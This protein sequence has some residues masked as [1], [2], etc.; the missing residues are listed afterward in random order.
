MTQLRKVLRKFTISV[1]KIG[2]FNV[3]EWREA[4]SF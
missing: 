4:K 3:A 1:G 2:V